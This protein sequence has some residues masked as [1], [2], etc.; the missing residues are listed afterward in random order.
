[1]PRAGAQKKGAE[2]APFYTGPP[3]RIILYCILAA[4]AFRK[5]RESSFCGTIPS[6]WKRGMRSPVI[7]PLSM[8]ATVAC[9]SFLANAHSSGVP[10]SS[11]R[12]ASAPVHAKMVATEL[13]EVSSPF[14][15]L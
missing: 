2:P 11:P 12:F 1:M 7:F 3:P 4:T 14:R 13:V 8:V 10:S 9:S 15:C 5:A 6:A